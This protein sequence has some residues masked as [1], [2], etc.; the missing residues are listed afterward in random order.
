MRNK[1]KTILKEEPTFRI[2]ASFEGPCLVIRK[3]AIDP[4]MPEC[5]REGNEYRFARKLEK[6]VVVQPRPLAKV[7]EDPALL[8]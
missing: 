4:G 7:L 8:G 1:G 3:W 6:S 5:W 2:E